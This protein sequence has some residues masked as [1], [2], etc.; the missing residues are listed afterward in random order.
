MRLVS[1]AGILIRGSVGRAAYG[2]AALLFPKVFDAVAPL[3]QEA[4][5]F[6]RLFGGRD[7]TIAAGAVAMVRKG[8]LRG[9]LGANF[10]CEVTDTIALVQEIRTRGGLDRSTWIGLAFNVAGY[11]TWLR[12]ALALGA[13][14]PAAERAP[15]LSE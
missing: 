8:E 4:R 11:A 13:D 2:A 10:A 5:Y 15:I 7:L 12:A 1:A 3:D 6:N 14:D 9:P